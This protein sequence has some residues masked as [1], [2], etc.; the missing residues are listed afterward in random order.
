[1]ST[2]VKK[3][4]PGKSP[5]A[6]SSA[7]T[8]GKATPDARSLPLGQYEVAQTPVKAV[9]GGDV[10]VLDFVATVVQMCPSDME[11]GH[12][13]PDSCVV[14]RMMGDRDRVSDIL[15]IGRAWPQ[16]SMKPGRVRLGWQ[17]FGLNQAEFEENTCI[18]RVVSLE[19]GESVVPRSIPVAKQVWLTASIASEFAR[20]SVV[21]APSPPPS[22]L[23]LAFV[24]NAAAKRVL[25]G[26]ALV[27]GSS[28]TVRVRGSPTVLSVARHSLQSPAA[29][30]ITSNLFT[31]GPDTV[32]T[33][34]SG[35]G[36]PSEVTAVAV[37]PEDAAP[38]AV[39]RHSISSVSASD[40]GGMRAQVETIQRMLHLPLRSPEV[41]T[42]LGLQPYR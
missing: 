33:V 29:S 31:V 30:G 36:T 25:R 2:P 24:M 6:S 20:L 4:T 28:V 26:S 17:L 8:K 42:T 35:S 21:D 22:D 18:I 19:A 40:I 38:G 12:I 5:A 27:D 16:K 23:S 1:M 41:F 9:V 34:V 32:V 10:A 15:G 3:S 13:R 14:L 7:G 11:H 37:S 39:V